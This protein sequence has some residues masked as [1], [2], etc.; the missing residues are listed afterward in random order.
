V[1]TMK[2]SHRNRKAKASA[3]S[4][5]RK[6]TNDA[7]EAF[8]TVEKRQGRSVKGMKG[9]FRL[10]LDG[11][12]RSPRGRRTVRLRKAA[13]EELSHPTIRQALSAIA[14]PVRLRVLAKLLEGPMIYRALK[15][16]TGLK[17]GP[18]YHHINQLRLGGLINPKERDLYESTPRGRNLI[19]ILMAARTLISDRAQ[20]RS[21]RSPR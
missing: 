4:R 17:P 10:E 5:L 13:L 2:R 7:Y 20:R 6:T 18:L 11:P 8:V 12:N 9:D 14:H 15:R 21:S 3:K 19:L 1:R 16:L